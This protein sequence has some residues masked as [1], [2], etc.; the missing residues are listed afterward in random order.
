MHCTSFWIIDFINTVLQ[1]CQLSKHR[2]KGSCK[3][4]L[5]NKLFCNV[6]LKNKGKQCNTIYTLQS[7]PVISLPFHFFNKMYR[8]FFTYYDIVYKEVFHMF[9]S[10]LHIGPV[11]CFFFLISQQFH[12]RLCFFYI[13]HINCF[14]FP[15]IL[16]EFMELAAH[17]AGLEASQVIW[18]ITF[19]GIININLRHQLT[20]EFM[21]LVQYL[22]FTHNCIRCNYYLNSEIL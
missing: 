8:V 11:V 15:I 1:W 13:R 7:Y 10:V 4:H 9:L 18:Q 14:P 5:W 2:W 19:Q 12:I 21:S 20:F 16:N 17:R 3:S 22:L 6:T